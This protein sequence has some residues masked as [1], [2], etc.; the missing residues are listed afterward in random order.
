MSKTD[1]TLQINVVI[2]AEIKQA[3]EDIRSMRRPIP[4]ISDAIRQAI[5]TERDSLRR[6]LGRA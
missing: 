4:S 5:L 6:K 3:I 1:R 2:D